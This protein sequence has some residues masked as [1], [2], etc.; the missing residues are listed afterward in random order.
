MEPITGKLCPHAEDGWDWQAPRCDQVVITDEE[1]DMHVKPHSTGYLYHPAAVKENK[2]RREEETAVR[3]HRWAAKDE[4]R[5]RRWAAEKKAEAQ[6]WRDGAEAPRTAAENEAK[7]KDHKTCTC[8]W[9]DWCTC[10]AARITEERMQMDAQ[11]PKAFDII[12]VS[13]SESGEIKDNYRSLCTETNMGSNTLERAWQTYRTKAKTLEETTEPEKNTEPGEAIEQGKT[14]KPEETSEPEV[15][16]ILTLR[17][18]QRLHCN[19]V[20][21]RD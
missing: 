15:I 4:T 16:A 13:T 17:G 10:S 9:I 6:S 18:T 2:H 3:V 21:R 11:S 8:P 5:A 1:A 20:R 12:S 7:S 14:P 19:N